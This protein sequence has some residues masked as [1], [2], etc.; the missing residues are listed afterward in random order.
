MGTS[1]TCPTVPVRCPPS[2]KGKPWARLAIDVEDGF[3][4][5]YVVA[6][7]KRAKV[8]E[9]KK[10]LASADELWLATDPDRE[11]EAIA[12]H[13]REVLKPKVPV[14]RMVFHEITREAIN[15]AAANTRDLDQDL[16]DAQEAR[17]LLDR[18]FGY[19][20]SPCCG[21]RS[22]RAVRG[23]GAVGGDCAWWS[24]A[25]GRG[26][27]SAPPGTGT[28]RGRSPPRVGSSRRSWSAID[29]SRV[30][31][32][33]DFG[34]DGQLEPAAAKAGA[35]R[36]DEPPRRARDSAGWRVLVGPVGD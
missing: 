30:A 13:L 33:G 25:S 22:C 36:L 18:L 3:K 19:E 26:S 9:L 5:Y 7:S 20:V 17:R 35:L 11:G 28:R 21:R 32:G 8:A 12:W 27:R 1:A 6:A 10:A 15:E 23:P 34:D 2:I 29:G 16:V 14:H 31:S 24:T 4:P